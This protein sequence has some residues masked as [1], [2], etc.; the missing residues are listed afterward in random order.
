MIRAAVAAAA[1][2]LALGAAAASPVAFVTDVGGSATIEGDG[3]VAFLAELEAGT[4]LFLGTGARV[5]VTFARSG[6]EFALAG[7]GEFLVSAE[8]VVAER[9]AAPARHDVPKLADTA[10][11]ARLSRSATASLRMRSA[12][13]NPAKAA[14]TALQYPVD[15]RI[16]TLQPAL[17][18]RAAQ[19]GESA[20]IR[21]HDESGRQVWSGKSA[22]GTARPPVRLAAATRYTWSVA[23]PRGALGEAQFETLPAE[24][25]AQAEKARSSARTFPER[26][27]HAVLLQDF[28][29]DQDAQ[30]AWAQLARERPD[31]PELARLAQ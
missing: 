28:G 10:V 19:K 6:S 26:V 22:N 12:A 1:A 13:A 15:T 23:T 3:K 5:S 16:A 27:L 18:W 4:R 7:P 8:G 29:A 21:L 30:A 24:R 14:A 17:R 9:G 11:I 31:L 2:A 20:T 25:L